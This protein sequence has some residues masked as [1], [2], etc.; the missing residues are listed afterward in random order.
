[1]KKDPTLE[2][3]F[4]SYFDGVQAPDVTALNGAKNYIR[5]N[6]RRGVILQRLGIAAACAACLAVTV[7]GLVYSPL[8]GGIKDGFD[9]VLHPDHSGNQGDDAPSADG[10]APTTVEYY[11]EN[12][13]FAAP[14]NVYDESNHSSLS[15]LKKIELAENAAVNTAESY[16]LD[17]QTAFVKADI[18]A[19]FNGTRHDAVICVEYL[20]DKV[21]SSFKDYYDGSQNYYYGTRYLL[22][23]TQENGEPVSKVTFENDNAKYYLYVKSSDYDAYFT[24]LNLILE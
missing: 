4:N 24:Y 23:R 12:G 14:V 3:Q 5:K 17:G 7:V 8:I 18:C 9:A 1:M 22:T 16:A 10:N 19:N 13:L 21:C 20:Q 15:F 6:K 2:S 11:D